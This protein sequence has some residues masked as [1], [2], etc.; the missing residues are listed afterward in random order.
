MQLG[1][2]AQV[3]ACQPCLCDTRMDSSD[4][5]NSLRIKCSNCSKVIRVPESARGKTGKCP[6]CGNRIQ[7]PKA[8]V[9]SKPTAAAEAK[10][11]HGRS[12]A[13][14]DA[15]GSSTLPEDISAGLRLVE[16][17]A[18]PAVWLLRITLLVMAI[19]IFVFW[20]LFEGERGS[21][22]EM[23]NFATF[24]AGWILF[25]VTGIFYLRWKYQANTNLQR[26]CKLPLKFTPG[27]CCGYY[28]FPFLN[29]FFPMRALHEIQAR[30]KASVG[31]MVY[32][33]WALLMLSTLIERAFYAQPGS[34]FLT[35]RD[36]VVLSAIA[37]MRIAAGLF[38]IRIIQAITEKQRRYRLAIEVG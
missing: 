1:R 26:T 30:S 19:R 7:I 12:V 5:D 9:A 23:A 22:I 38:L 15:P 3:S 31:Y 14:A 37:G 21:D 33:W 17:R 34:T 35:G 20:C 18:V 2:V 10:T 25:F 11:K 4:S 29:F 13:S 28:F 8:A 27:R 6:Q 16:S 32:V 36:W 24:I